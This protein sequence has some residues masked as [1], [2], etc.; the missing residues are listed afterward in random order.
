MANTR[1]LVKFYQVTNSQL[2]SLTKVAGQLIFVTDTK[3]LYLDQTN[4]N[5]IEIAS[6][7]LTQNGTDGHILTFTNPQGTETTI[8]IPDNN[9]TYELTADT[10]NNKI[11]LTPN[12]GEAQSITVP[13]ATKATNDS[14]GNAIN[15]TYLKKSGG[16][17]TGAI[18]RSLAASGTIADTNLF[19]VSGSS[20]GF[21]V[22]YA[23]TSADT[24]VTTFSTTDDANAKLSL[25]NTISGTYKE[26]IGIINGVPTAP[27]ADAA[28]N[29]T[30]I[31]TTEFVKTAIDNLPE[32][33]V[34]RGSLGTGGTI[35]DLPVDGSAAI[36]DTYKVIT[37][38]TYD[39]KAAKVGDAFICLTKT[40]S[41][42]TWELI[43]SG[44][45][46]SGTVTSIKIKA[47]GPIAVDSDAAITT[48]GERTISHA[49]SGVT[50]GTY[51]SVTVNE[52]GHVTG[53]T[54]P[55]TIS[56]YGI[57]DANISNGVITLGNQTITPLTST[58]LN[59]AVDLNDQTIEGLYYATGSNSITNKPSGIN[60]FGLK[61]FK[62]AGGYITQEIIEGNTNPGRRWTRQYN[63]STWSDWS[64]MEWTDTIPSGYCF[65][66]AGTAAKEASCSNYQILNNSYLQV[67]MQ[68]SNTSA[69]A[70][71]FKVNNKTACPIYINGIASSS[72]NY[73][74]PAGSYLT[75]YDGTNYYFRTDGKITGSITGDAAT[76]NGKTVGVNVPADAVFTD[77]TYDD[78]T[79]SAHGLMSTTD[80]AKL[81]YT[82]VTYAT[83][84]T[85]AATAAKVV[86]V[87][88]NSNW[89]LQTGAIVVVSFSNTNSASNPTLNVNSTG[90][91]SIKYN[92]ALVTTANLDIV[93]TANKPV[94]YMYDGTNYVWLGQS[95]ASSGGGGSSHEIYSGSTTPT[96]STGADGD[97]YIL[98]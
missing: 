2:S 22:N 90:A 55:T 85:A 43:P 86:T 57:T 67:I 19:T 11:T 63:G 92:S 88:G 45:E 14:D 12:S 73:T 93:G 39:S 58:Q 78:A 74:L 50:A 40:S 97:I 72:T 65:T 38:G 79:T 6:Y 70:L 69:S 66:A 96:A 53:G 9:T 32:P 8:T 46:P 42:N 71:T 83:C 80:K 44:D 35:T 91:K 13:Y 25:G 16:A 59:N 3:R 37:A 81:N 36:G 94:I 51:R 47:T 21:K 28:T 7:N 68:N 77:T 4:S 48:S 41:A 29:S 60:A 27:T 34:F 52:T 10:T 84:D 1:T 89:A 76:V 18:T 33:M 87:S 98:I 15:S 62:T 5:R 64:I 56:G 61:V 31:A 82:N 30:Q 24:G 49:T 17:M 26:A 54:N 75:Y 20:D 95:V 23:S